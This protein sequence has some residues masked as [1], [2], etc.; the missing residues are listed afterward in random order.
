MHRLSTVEE[1][2]EV[3]DE[4]VR[5]E[6]IGVITRPIRSLSTGAG[7][8]QILSYPYSFIARGARYIEKV[9]QR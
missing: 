5:A 1:R 7:L 3:D 4:V 6:F 2:G 8:F 9:S